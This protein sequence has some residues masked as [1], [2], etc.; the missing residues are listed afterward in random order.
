MPVRG[1][2]TAM[3]RLNGYAGWLPRA[4]GRDGLT[5]AGCD[6]G[7]VTLVGGLP[8]MGWRPPCAPS[9]LPSECREASGSRRPGSV[10]W[11]GSQR[12]GGSEAGDGSG[13][14]VWAPTNPRPSAASWAPA[15]GRRSARLDVPV[16]GAAGALLVPR[17]RPVLV[18]WKVLARM[19]SACVCGGFVNRDTAGGTAHHRNDVSCRSSLRGRRP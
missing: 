19:A 6:A 8:H 4:H 12:A 7:T 9:G 15:G 11:G 3:H 13:A 2:G 16:C 1:P 17:H 14:P 18:S 10:G 5:R